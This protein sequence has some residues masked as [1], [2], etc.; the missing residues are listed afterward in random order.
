MIAHTGPTSLLMIHVHFSLWEGKIS[1]RPGWCL[2][3][4]GVIRAKWH[5]F[6]LCLF[7]LVI[8][9]AP[10]DLSVGVT[11]MVQDKKKSVLGIFSGQFCL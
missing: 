6:L 5:R 7:T 11:D 8:D 10:G 3:I 4:K 1:R 2:Q 9:L